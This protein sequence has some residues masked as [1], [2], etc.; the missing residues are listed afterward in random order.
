M[1]HFQMKMLLWFFVLAL[2]AAVATASLEMR[3]HSQLEEPPASLIR[4]PE[5]DK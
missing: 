4:C 1:L 3:T 2:V 5:T